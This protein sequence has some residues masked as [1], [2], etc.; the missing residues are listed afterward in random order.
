VHICAR[1]IRD[2]KEVLRQRCFFVR[3]R[4]MMRN[5]IHRLL[6]AQHDLQ[7]PQ[8]SDLFGAKGMSFLNQLEL[9]APA[10]FLLRQQLALLRELA[11][12]IQEDEKGLEGMIEASPAL[13]YVR[14]KSADI[15]D[16]ADHHRREDGSHSR[17]VTNGC[18]GP[19]SKPLG[20]RWGARLI[21]ESFIAASAPWVRRPTVPSWRRPD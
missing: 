10:G 8:C 16:L 17:N 7:L 4:T 13:H 21:L 6:G 15:I 1:S 12:R 5:R 19:S 2:I 11:V 3:Q 9:P 14:S 20:W 18:A